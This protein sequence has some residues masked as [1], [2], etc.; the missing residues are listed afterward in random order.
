MT[1]YTTKTGLQIGCR[2]QVPA[3]SLGS[4]A[5]RIQS[6]LLGGSFPGSRRVDRKIKRA[7][8]IHTD[9]SLM[10]RVL[11]ALTRKH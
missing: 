9:N 10:A 8:V 2:Y 5:E 3:P 11:R 6:A 4:D 7:H 1:P